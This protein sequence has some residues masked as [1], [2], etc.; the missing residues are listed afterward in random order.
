MNAI[1]KSLSAISRSPLLKYS[2]LILLP[3][4]VA[5]LLIPGGIGHLLSSNEFMPRAHCYLRNPKIITLHVAADALIGLSYICISLTLA[6]L[7]YKARRDIPFHWM[8]LA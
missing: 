6:Y 5:A 3:V 1:F 7:V 2:A 8:F 4:L